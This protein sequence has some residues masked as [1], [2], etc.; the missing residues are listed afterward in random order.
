MAATVLILINP[1]LVCS[2]FTHL[3]CCDCA[4][5]GRHDSLA[6]GQKAMIGGFRIVNE[7]KLAALPDKVFLEM[8]RSGALTFVF[9]HLMSMANWRNILA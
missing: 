8:H 6:G 1:I 5:P 9:C 7:K 4:L 2:R 3:K